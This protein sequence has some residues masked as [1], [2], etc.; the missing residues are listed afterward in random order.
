MRKAEALAGLTEVC[1]TPL[2]HPPPPAPHRSRPGNPPR[3]LGAAV[4]PETPQHGG[5]VARW[6]RVGWRPT[7]HPGFCVGRSKEKDLRARA[8][9]TDG[10]Q[11]V[12]PWVTGELW[13]A[14][15][16]TTSASVHLLPRTRRHLAIRERVIVSPGSRGMPELPVGGWIPHDTC[17]RLGLSR[18]YA[19]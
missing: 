19:V 3:L 8:G 18:R 7:L 5:P 15:L 10:H 14:L 4:F 1:D 11:G 17:S 6:S 13:V 16:G 9:W 2:L 12:P